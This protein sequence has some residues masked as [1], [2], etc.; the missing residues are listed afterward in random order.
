MFQNVFT[1]EFVRIWSIITDH[2]LVTLVGLQGRNEGTSSVAFE[3]LVINCQMCFIH[4]FIF[5]C[6]T[7]NIKLFIF[8]L[9]DVKCLFSEKHVFRKQKRTASLWSY[10]PASLVLDFKLTWKM[11]T[12]SSRHKEIFEVPHSMQDYI[13][14]QIPDRRYRTNTVLTF[15]DTPLPQLWGKKICEIQ[16][17]LWNKKF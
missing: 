11:M 17:R 8:K 1:N 5:N 4:L 12:R 2:F 15:W 16:V 9:F 10:G 7:L 13:K 14:M 3:V 6:L